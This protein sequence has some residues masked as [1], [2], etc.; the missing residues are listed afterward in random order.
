[1]SWRALPGSRRGG[2]PI[3]AHTELL[4]GFPNL[5]AYRDR[6]LSRPAYRKAVADQCADFARHSPADMKYELRQET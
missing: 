3:I 4:T 2:T 6:C 1:M 5:V